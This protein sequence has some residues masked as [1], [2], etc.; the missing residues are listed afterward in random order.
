MEKEL[1]IENLEKNILSLKRIN[2]QS[3]AI[4]HLANFSNFFHNLG[5]PETF[6]EV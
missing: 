2:F 3:F 4:H 6:L 5:I 1:N